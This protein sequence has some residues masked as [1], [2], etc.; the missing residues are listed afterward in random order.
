MFSLLLCVA[1]DC[2]LLFVFEF[3]L[4]FVFS[5]CYLFR[6]ESILVLLLCIVFCSCFCVFVFFCGFRYLLLFVTREELKVRE[7]G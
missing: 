2:S 1:V 5:V 3:N 4:W 7:G 6:V